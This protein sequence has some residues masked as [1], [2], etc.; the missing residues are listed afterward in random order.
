MGKNS[1]HC[2]SLIYFL[3]SES[4]LDEC[5]LRMNGQIYDHSYE[6]AWNGDFVY[7]SCGE[8][9]LENDHQEYWGGIR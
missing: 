5:P 6:C 3:G 1:M 2:Q 8:H 4:R 7:V 9:N